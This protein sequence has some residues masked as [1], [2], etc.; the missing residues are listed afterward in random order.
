MD[1]LVVV[2][3]SNRQNFFCML[4]AHHIAIE[5]IFYLQGRGHM[6]RRAWSL[7][8]ALSNNLIAQTNALVA[9]INGGAR[10]QLANLLLRFPT[11]GA[12]QAPTLLTLFHLNLLLF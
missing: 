10:N 8:L 1:A 12:R 7:L 6:R 2:I 4:L 5:E 11:K 3:D 9:N